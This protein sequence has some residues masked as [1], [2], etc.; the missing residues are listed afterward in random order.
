MPSG[1]VNPRADRL[2]CAQCLRN[3]GFGFKAITQFTGVART[4]LRRKLPPTAQK[5]KPINIRKGS[6]G[7]HRPRSIAPLQL[8]V[9]RWEQRRFQIGDEQIHWGNH[10]EFFRWR[11]RKNAS[12]V[13]QRQKAKRSN[14]YIARLLRSRI[15][16]VV[17]GLK[18]AP[19]LT[20]LGCSLEH[21]RKHLEQQ[22]QPGMTWANMGSYWEIDHIRP[23]A[24]FDL[25][26]ADEQ[27]RCFHFSNLQPLTVGQNRRKHASYKEA[28]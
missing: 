2:P 7:K 17:N 9:F 15:W 20:L 24:S 13:F 3:V 11:G 25:R 22:F 21:L 16:R 10:P 18:S 27:R 19:T 14:S 6:K 28:A 5:R 12:Q 8:A 26:R 1:R 23:C 4:T